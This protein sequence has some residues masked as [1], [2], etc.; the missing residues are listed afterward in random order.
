MHNATAHPRAR[1]VSLL[2]GLSVAG[3]SLL[4]AAAPAQA[5]NLQDWEKIAAC[6]SDGNWST[7]TGNGFYGGLQF[8]E[9]SWRGVGGT[10]LPHQASKAEQIARAEKLQD[11][12]GWGAWPVCSKK[13]G[14]S[15]KD[16]APDAV[17]PGAGSAAVKRV[18][19]QAL[20][21]T[22]TAYERTAAKGEALK[23]AT[24][25]GTPV[26]VLEA[27]KKA[28]AAHEDKLAAAERTVFVTPGDSLYK[29]AREHGV[30][31]G[32][33]ALYQANR[34]II[35]NPD[36]IYVGQELVLPTS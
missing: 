29:I 26:T 16:A 32:W 28:D 31:G 19:R 27:A 1:H 30:A 23:E 14:L 13:A 17:V 11:L 10:G 8:S 35:E 36:L 12:Q 25:V 22:T 24:Q 4:G 33:K 34:D 2:A 9:T 3:A 18:E 7:N 20:P 21:T 15:G 6:E 5:A